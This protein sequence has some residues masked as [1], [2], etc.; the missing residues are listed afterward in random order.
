V[1]RRRRVAGFTLI[2][3][4]IAISIL[5]MLSI[6]IYGAFANMRR[7]KQ[8]LE[9]IGDRD[10]EGRNAMARIVRDLSSAYISAHL[11]PDVSM[12]VVKTAFIGTSGTPADRIDFNSFSNIRRDR[13]SHVS[14]QAEISYYGDP[15]PEDPQKIDLVRRISEYPDLEPNKGGRIEVLATDIDLFEVEYLDPQTGMWTETWDT[16]Q[17]AGQANRMPLQVRVTLVLKNGRRDGADRG[18]NLLRFATQF[19]LPI[20]NQLTFGIQ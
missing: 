9:R 19:P 14:D 5:S 17:A 3:L 2:E 7:T 8:G 4:L 10:R 1:R 20:Q 6:L 12:A 16:T 11:P 18:R 15:D 13:N